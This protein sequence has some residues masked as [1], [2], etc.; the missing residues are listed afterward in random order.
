MKT[1]VVGLGNTIRGDDGIG[2]YVARRLKN[3]FNS[4]EVDIM[5]THYAGIKL[6]DLLY[7]YNKVFIIDAVKNGVEAGRVSLFDI[8]EDPNISHKDFH[9]MNFLD[10]YIR[11]KRTYPR[12]PEDLKVIGIS[13]NGGDSFEEGLSQELKNK[14]PEITE[15]VTGMIR[16]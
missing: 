16:S 12:I 11:L 3:K 8:E 9:G 2:V 14:L 7:D 6:M 1:L 4:G 10:S 5:E 13:I 15:K